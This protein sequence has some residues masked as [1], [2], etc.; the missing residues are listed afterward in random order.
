M[1]LDSLK[2]LLSEYNINEYTVLDELPNWDSLVLLQ[3][4]I[5]IEKE[6]KIEIPAEKVIKIKTIGDII[7]IIEESNNAL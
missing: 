6:F 3:F 4:L 2:V 5:S 1:I 7:K